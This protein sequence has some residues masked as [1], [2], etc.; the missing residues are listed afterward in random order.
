MSKQKTEEV[1][2]EELANRYQRRHNINAKNGYGAKSPK[3][4][5]S[6]ALLYLATG[7]F[8]PIK[9]D[10]KLLYRISA[11]SELSTYALERLQ[12]E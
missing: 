7:S 12:K 9:R 10:G 2:L 4:H 5:F 3:G 1:S 8:K 6:L 11:Q